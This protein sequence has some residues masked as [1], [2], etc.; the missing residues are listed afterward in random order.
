[1]RG[2]YPDA[3]GKS[4]QGDKII[5]SGKPKYSTNSDLVH[6]SRAL[7]E[8]NIPISLSADAEEFVCNSL[9]YLTAR[10]IY[11]D[12]LQIKFA[13]F[14]TPW[15]SDYLSRINLEPGKVTIPK[16]DLRKTIEV[17]VKEIM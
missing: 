10:T 7:T 17:L 6:L 14:H 15:T 12:R 13:F 3:N 1:M 9:I 5:S 2:K 8:A 4:P 16:N 11:R